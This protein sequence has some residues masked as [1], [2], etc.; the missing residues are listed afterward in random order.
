MVAFYYASPKLQLFDRKIDSNPKRI[1][2]RMTMH[3]LFLTDSAGGWNGMIGE[4]IRHEADLAIGPLTISST[5]CGPIDATF[6]A[7]S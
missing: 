3:N 4:L 1:R 2:C 6:S 7:C 5:R